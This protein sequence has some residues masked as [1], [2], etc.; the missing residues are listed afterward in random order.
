[1]CHTYTDTDTYAYSD[2]NLLLV[3]SLVSPY[4][5]PNTY[6]NSDTNTY[7]DAGLSVVAILVPANSYS[8]SAD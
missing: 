3:G 5:Y 8:C 4:P 7:F 1:M 6:A 2:T